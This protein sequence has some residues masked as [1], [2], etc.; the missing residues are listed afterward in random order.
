MA[1]KMMKLIVMTMI[2]GNDDKGPNSDQRLQ[3]M[4]VSCKQRNVKTL[5][6]R[7]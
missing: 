6:A 3:S 4:S 5:Q 2:M 1:M 7:A